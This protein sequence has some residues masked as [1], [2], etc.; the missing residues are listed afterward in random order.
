MDEIKKG[1]VEKRPAGGKNLPVGLI[2]IA[3]ILAGVLIYMVIAYQGK[4]KEEG[5]VC[6]GVDA[7]KR[8]GFAG[9]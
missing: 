9:Q 1:V 7:D 3:V 4:K 5:D 8:E 6:D 2:A